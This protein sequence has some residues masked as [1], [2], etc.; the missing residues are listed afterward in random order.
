VTPTA[1]PTCGRQ[2]ADQPGVA[3]VMVRH[4]EH[5]WRQAWVRPDSWVALSSTQ[6]NGTVIGTLP[7]TGPGLTRRGR[8]D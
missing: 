1:A 4:R 3:A 6:P 2:P 8:P 7:A 5:R